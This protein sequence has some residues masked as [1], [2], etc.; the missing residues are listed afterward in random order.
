MENDRIHS[1]EKEQ[2]YVDPHIGQSTSTSTLPSA[3]QYGGFFSLQRTIGNRA[4]G[5][6]LQAKLT[7]SRPDDK[8]EREADQVADQVLRMPEPIQ[9]FP[10]RHP[11]RSVPYSQGGLVD[12]LG[13]GVRL[14]PSAQSLMQRKFGHDLSDVRIHTDGTADRLARQLNT[15]A[16]SMQNHIAFQANYYRPDL[17]LGQYILAHELAHV[18]QNRNRFTQR[19]ISRYPDDHQLSPLSVDSVNAWPYS[20]PNLETESLHTF[21]WLIAAGILIATMLVPS[22]LAPDPGENAPPD[23]ID[24]NWIYVPI[25]GSIIQMIQGRNWL[26]QGAGFTFLFFDAAGAGAML[27]GAWVLLNSAGRAGMRALGGLGLQRLNREGVRGLSQAAAR[28]EID[29]ALHAGH[30]IIGNEGWLNHSVIYVVE[31]G[32]IYRLHGSLTRLTYGATT[33]EVTGET[34]T[35]LARRLNEVTIVSSQGTI[36][37]LRQAYRALHGLQWHRRIPIGCAGTQSLIL[38]RAGFGS[39][40]P[41]GISRYL[42]FMF[43]HQGLM[44][45]SARSIHSV[46]GLFGVGLHGFAMPTS[47][48]AIPR[49]VYVLANPSYAEPAISSAT[50]LPLRIRSDE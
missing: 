36:M 12:R 9:R 40:V 42:P 1:V 32:R 43:R 49:G 48:M 39:L 31:N 10:R 13:T 38:E 6:L 11:P 18:V 4:V 33:R 46:R 47:L 15:H 14:D 17:P 34:A 29:A 50:G 7:V 28:Q 35:A 23:L 21:P 26:E 24:T 41:R 45:G 2:T 22:R 44:T 27:K 5:R 8:A 20:D 16:F 37:D 30:A 3:D 25:I 19:N